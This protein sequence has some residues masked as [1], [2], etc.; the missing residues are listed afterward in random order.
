M[1]GAEMAVETIEVIAHLSNMLKIKRQRENKS[2]PK[3]LPLFGDFPGRNGFIPLRNLEGYG[4]GSHVPTR[5][6]VTADLGRVI[7]P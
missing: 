5:S 1:S 6:D 7:H 4:A 2:H 3:I